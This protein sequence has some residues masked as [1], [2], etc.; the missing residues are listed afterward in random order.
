MESK[1]PD[2]EKC[3]EIRKIEKQPLSQEQQIPSAST[4]SIFGHIRKIL[5]KAISQHPEELLRRSTGLKS[6]PPPALSS[7]RLMKEMSPVSH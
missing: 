2:E 7:T 5:N 3:W 4:G 1:F 6:T